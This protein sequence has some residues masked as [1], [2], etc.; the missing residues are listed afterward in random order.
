[1]ES[2]SANVKS[3]DY[4]NIRS[5]SNFQ[6]IRTVTYIILNFVEAFKLSCRVW[7]SHRVRVIGTA[8][9]LFD[10]VIDPGSL[11]H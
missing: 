9:I 2:S 8:L 5:G 3:E 10:M 1:M 11:L 6:H 4:I 7:R